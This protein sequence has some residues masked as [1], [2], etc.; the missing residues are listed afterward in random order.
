MRNVLIEDALA[1]PLLFPLGWKVKTVDIE[2]WMVSQSL[3][4]P[5]ELIEIWSSIGGGDF[6]ESE[7]LLVPNQSTFTDEIESIEATT[8]FLVENGFQKEFFVIHKG[9]VVSAVKQGT[10]SIFV[11]S[12]DN[13]VSVCIYDSFENWYKTEFRDQFGTKYGLK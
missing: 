9:C 11:F 12:A 1:N 3:E 10:Q 8:S 4:L 6:L 2:N 13:Y 7:T 5:A